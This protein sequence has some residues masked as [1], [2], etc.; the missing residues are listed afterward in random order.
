MIKIR[1]HII[2]SE[3]MIIVMIIMPF[4]RKQIYKK[5]D[6]QNKLRP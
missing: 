1:Q 6:L 5:K 4:Q 2:M 3:I